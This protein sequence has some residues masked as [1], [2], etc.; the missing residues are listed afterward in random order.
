MAT[1]GTLWL[2]MPLAL[3]S[4]CSLENSYWG[5]LPLAVSN[6][7]NSLKPFTQLPWYLGE[8]L[9][10]DFHKTLESNYLWDLYNFFKHSKNWLAN[11]TN[12]GTTEKKRGKEPQM[13]KQ[14]IQAWP[15]IPYFLVNENKSSREDFTPTFAL[16]TVMFLSKAHW[17]LKVF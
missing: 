11:Q 1:S 16:Y 17:C 5:F 10:I 15:L 13:D 9:I 7:P 8:H 3:G 14:I 12:P 2:W 6:V 4:S